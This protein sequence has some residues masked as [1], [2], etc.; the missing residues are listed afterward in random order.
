MSAFALGLDA[1][2]ADPNLGEDALWKAGGVGAGV[3]VRVVRRSP[4]RVERFG[5]S[6]ALLDSL[7]VDLRRSDAPTLAEGDVVEI[8]GT[9]FRVIAEPVADALGLTWTAEL[10]P[11]DP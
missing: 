2:F 9:A 7:A 8:G 3:P 5:D 4:D 6:R 11:T 10:T 1:I